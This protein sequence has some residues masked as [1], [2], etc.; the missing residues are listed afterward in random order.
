MTDGVFFRFRT[1][2]KSKLM[3]HFPFLIL[4]LNLKLKAA[5]LCPIDGLFKFPVLVHV[6]SLS[7]RHQHFAKLCSSTDIKS[8][9]LVNKMML[10]ITI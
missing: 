10:R 1:E 7:V 6:G 5:L 3:A 8:P 4:R 2:I 9:G